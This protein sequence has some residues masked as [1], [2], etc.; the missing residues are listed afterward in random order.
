MGKASATGSEDEDQTPSLFGWFIPCRHCWCPPT[1]KNG[2]SIRGLNRNSTDL[3]FF[4]PPSHPPKE[5]RTTTHQ[6]HQRR[7]TV[8][9]STMFSAIRSAV[10]ARAPLGFRMYTMSSAM[11]A[12]SVGTGTCAHFL[13]EASRFQGRDR[14]GGHPPRLQLVV[15]RC[16]IRR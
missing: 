4:I 14:T 8:S 9:T 2:Q 16:V 6:Q 7:Q 3:P 1:G 13:H 11:L 15:C 12:R 5:P 10:I